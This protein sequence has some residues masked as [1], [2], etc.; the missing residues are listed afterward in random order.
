MDTE[1]KEHPVLLVAPD[2]GAFG[3]V[4]EASGMLKSYIKDKYGKEMDVYSGYLDKKRLGG[5]KVV[6]SGSVLE[7]EGKPLSSVDVKDCWVFVLDDET[8]WGS[9]LLAANYALVRKSGAA[10]HR[11]L[12]GVVHGKLAQGM[13]PFYTGLEEEEIL[14]AMNAGKNI[15]PRPEYI[16]EA[17]ELMPPRLFLCTRSVSLPEGFPEA[18]SASIGPIIGF[19][20]K[21]LIGLGRDR[22]EE[23]VRQRW[24]YIRQ[25]ID[26]MNRSSRDTI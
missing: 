3:Y 15:E 22:L 8:S 20:V 19:A 5:K 2:D 18:N 13:K 11:V 21:R 14:E 4:K 12:T 1:F 9:T 26:N 17:E 23:P 25:V 16:N 24:D 6:I 10:W 7:D